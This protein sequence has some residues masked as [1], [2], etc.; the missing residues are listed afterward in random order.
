MLPSAR[1]AIRTKIGAKILLRF[2]YVHGRT[3]QLGCDARDAP[4]ILELS[5]QFLV[6]LLSGFVLLGVLINCFVF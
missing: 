5:V 6:L 4:E 3:R 1:K 2:S